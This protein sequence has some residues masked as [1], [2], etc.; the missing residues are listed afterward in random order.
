MVNW[1][2][3]TKKL[4]HTKYLNMSTHLN[5]H[6]SIFV[7]LRNGFGRVLCDAS[8]M[9]AW[10]TTQTPVA[11]IADIVLEQENTY[12]CMEFESSGRL[13]GLASWISIIEFWVRGPVVSPANSPASVSSI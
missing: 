5:T 1:Q 11:C 9:V 8:K 12:S 4:S 10:E 7:S 3:S 2:V 6:A 13:G